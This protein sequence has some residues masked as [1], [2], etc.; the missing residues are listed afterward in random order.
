LA[1]SIFNGKNYGTPK[2]IRHLERELPKYD[3][4]IEKQAVIGLNKIQIW[5]LRRVNIWTKS[6]LFHFD[7]V[8]NAMDFLVKE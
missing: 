7:S 4:L 6:K 8:R 2:F 1:L 5:I 3:H